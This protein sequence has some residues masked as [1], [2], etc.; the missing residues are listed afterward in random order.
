MSPASRNLALVHWI[1]MCISSVGLSALGPGQAQPKALSIC[2]SEWTVLLSKWF[3]A[4]IV[5]GKQECMHTC[6]VWCGTV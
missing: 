2:I 6:V 1:G 3:Q 4:M 5:L